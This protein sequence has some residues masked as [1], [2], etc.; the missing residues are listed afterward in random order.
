[1]TSCLLPTLLLFFSQSFSNFQQGNAYNMG[2]RDGFS[3]S[4]IQKLNSM[5]KCGNIPSQGIINR[6]TYP[7]PTYEKPNRPP[8]V[9][10][11]V[12]GYT[13][14]LAQ[15]VGGIANIFSGLGGK[16]EGDFEETNDLNED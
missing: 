10:S 11:T 16:K 12:N 7:V 1:M 15:F 2:Q 5:Y 6:P 13:N 4:D 8:I 9:G 14:P 3:Q